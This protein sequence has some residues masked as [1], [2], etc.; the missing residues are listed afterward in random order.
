MTRKSLENILLLSAHASDIFIQISYSCKVPVEMIGNSSPNITLSLSL[1]VNEGSQVKLKSIRP[2]HNTLKF[3]WNKKISHWQRK[4][5]IVHFRPTGSASWRES[6]TRPE[7]F[8]G[9]SC[10][11]KILIGHNGFFFLIKQ[12]WPILHLEC[13]NK[14]VYVFVCLTGVLSIRLHSEVVYNI[15]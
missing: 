11:S 14:N 6:S 8:D 9:V 4:I 1:S 5:L 2:F 3:N 12:S 15:P 7:K 13:L 10:C